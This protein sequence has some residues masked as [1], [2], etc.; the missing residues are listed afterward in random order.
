MSLGEI[1]MLVGGVAIVA[2]GLWMLAR[3]RAV[4][5]YLAQMENDTT[6]RSSLLNRERVERLTASVD[7]PGTRLLDR[8]KAVFLGLCLLLAGVSLIVNALG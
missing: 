1:G 4:G 6:R 2:C 7:E 5:E 3:N 8:T